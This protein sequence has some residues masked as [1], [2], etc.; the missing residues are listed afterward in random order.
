LIDAGLHALCE[1]RQGNLWIGTSSGLN[2]L[3]NGKFST[4][5]SEGV[6]TI[7]EDHQG[8]LWVGTENGLEC[9]QNGEWTRFTRNDG[10][11]DDIITAI[12]EDKDNTLWIGTA[13]GGL[14]RMRGRRFTSYTIRQGLFSDEI[15]SIVEDD[16][17]WL[18]MS[19]SRG[20]FRA[21]ARDFDAYDAGRAQWIASIAYGRTDGMESPQCNGA[22]KPA[23]WKSRDGRLWFPTSKGVVA[24]D[25]RTMKI[26]HTPP[27]VYVNQVL[28]DKQPLR[29]PGADD[30]PLHVRPGRGELEFHYTAISLSAAEKVR[31]KYKLDRIDSDWVDAGNRRTAYYNNVSPGKYRFQVIACNKDGIWNDSG[32][33]VTFEL[34]PYYWQTWWFRGL[35]ALLVIGGAS[36]TALYA[37]RRRMQRQLQ[38]LQQR[39][40]IEKERGR[41]AKDIH[42]DLGSSLTRI[43]MLGERVEEGLGKREDVGT[44]INKI[45]SSARHTVQSLD[46]IVWAV[47]PENDTL[48]GLLEYIGHYADE[49][50]ENT[51]VN[52]RL[53]L[54]VE[55]PA[56]NLPAETR[57][58]LFLLVKEALNNALK[59]SGATEVRVEVSV[60]NAL[61]RILVEDNGRGFDLAAAA[62]RK[63]NGLEN[64][65]KRIENLGGQFEIASA[66][67][68]GT[69]LKCG[70]KLKA[71]P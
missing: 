60:E 35:L 68:Q 34:E 61:V 64:M 63:G 16:E 65:R 14:N 33:A 19:C 38:L 13:S 69:S 62:H 1:D 48:N 4:Q 36:G 17:G 3:T 18:W 50:F 6:R 44:H 15:F 21:R 5:F 66:P 12:Y 31:F 52:C 22:G 20:V 54:P 53:E 51:D 32:A 24:V 9:R 23:V 58:N 2:C 8:T 37:T 39:H 11:S 57:H 67:G 29:E 42:D 41:I 7:L 56:F 47:N 49:F 55:V 43:M 71:G 46:E 26:D 70:L 30:T 59:H 10:L 40:A 25:P 27:P 45:V 28:V